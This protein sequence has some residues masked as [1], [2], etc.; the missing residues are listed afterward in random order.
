MG[1]RG[2]HPV[3]EEG[4]SLAS[5]CRRRRDPARRCGPPPRQAGQPG[6]PGQRR[7]LH[8]A[9]QAP[10]NR[11]EAE[12]VPKPARCR[13]P[14]RRRRGPSGP[15]PISRHGGA[16]APGVPRLLRDLI[17]R[18]GG[19]V[20][21][22]Q[23]PGFL[24]PPGFRAAAAGR[25]EEAFG[26]GS[27]MKDRKQEEGGGGKSPPSPTETTT[28]PKLQETLNQRAEPDQVV[29]GGHDYT[30]YYNPTTRTGAGGRGAET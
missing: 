18:A 15:E 13:T 22:G 25:R 11:Q 1:S 16:I 12:P 20:P 4:V 26:L 10:Q 14:G 24:T 27:H 6:H 19:P 8:H 9:Q 2:P 30:L 3:P 28:R 17:P 7:L 5:G 23:Q 29:I 21:A